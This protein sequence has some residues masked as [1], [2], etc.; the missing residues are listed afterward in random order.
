MTC[1][2]LP[3]T[4]QPKLGSLV[5]EVEKVAE[6]A[7][8]VRIRLYSSCLILDRKLDLPALKEM[9]SDSRIRL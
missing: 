6:L 2:D 3:T 4:F 9:K 5:Q 7:V 1:C 8:T